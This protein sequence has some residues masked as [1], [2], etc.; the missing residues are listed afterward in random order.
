MKH[1][2]TL[3]L[4]FPFTFL[5]AS[6][7]AQQ[8][9]I[10]QVCHT[11]QEQYT[12]GYYTNNGSY[13]QGGVYSV[14]NTV[15]CQSGEVYSSQPYSGG[16]NVYYQQPYY[17]GGGYYGR[18]TNPNCNPSRTVLGAVL[19]GAIGRSMT[20]TRNNRNNRG[21]ATALGASVGG[22]VFSC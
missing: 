19:G 4:L 22:L 8:V 12:P 11:Y 9:N 21:W 13:I 14:K 17:N 10:Y 16:S 18:R 7:E 20:S 15:N 2:L 3:S 5:P 1:L 6:V